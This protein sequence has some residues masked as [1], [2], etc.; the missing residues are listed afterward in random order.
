MYD[1]KNS[2]LIDQ[3]KDFEK[4]LEKILDD[5]KYLRVSSNTIKGTEILKESNKLTQKFQ[6]LED[7]ILKS[8]DK[9]QNTEKELEQFNKNNKNDIEVMFIVK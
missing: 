8:L 7:N 5:F 2:E 4:V 3:N 6:E 9:K 1:P